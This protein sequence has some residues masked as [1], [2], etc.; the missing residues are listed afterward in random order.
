MT[1]TPSWEKQFWIDLYRKQ[2]PEVTYFD[3][4]QEGWDAISELNNLLKPYQGPIRIPKYIQSYS[5]MQSVQPVNFYGSRT[6]F[7][8]GEAQTYI[9][10]KG[11]DFNVQVQVRG[12]I[13]AFNPTA[14]R[15][16]LTLFITGLLY[17]PAKT[18]IEYE[19]LD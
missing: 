11:N 3:L 19:V 5:C 14:K 1:N 10:M 12:A 7:V 9:N 16:A 6:H 18:A 17:S 15:E 4:K 2:Y 8:R 13:N